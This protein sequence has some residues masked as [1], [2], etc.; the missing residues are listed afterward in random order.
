MITVCKYHIGEITTERQAC[1]DQL[2]SGLPDNVGYELIT[3]KIETMPHR[4][5][6]IK[7]H[8]VRRDA[9]LVRLKL[10]KENPDRMWIDTDVKI[11]Y[12]PD[13]VEGKTYFGKKCC[14]SSIM[15][16]KGAVDSIYNIMTEFAK[17]WQLCS[18]RWL[19][20]LPHELISDDAFEHL[21]L[22]RINK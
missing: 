17:S 6:L 14:P 7:E 21:Y 10:L 2:R 22:S 18:H 4:P 13:L 19:I 15:Y 11:N 16:L 9:G 1:I 5:P 8:T 3:T 12:W 20:K